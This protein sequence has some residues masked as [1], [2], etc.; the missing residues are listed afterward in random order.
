MRIVRYKLRG[1][2]N[3]LW[4]WV[5]EG[6]VGSLDGD[7]FGAFR[8]KKTYVSLDRVQL[9]P[10]VQ[11]GKIIAVGRNYA[12]HADE[13]GA[14]VPEIPLIFLKP[15]SSVIADGDTI[16]LP[17]QSE[18]VEHEAELAV[19]IGQGGRW[20]KRADAHKHVL[21]Y[22][23][24]VDVTARDLQ[25]SDTVWTRGKGFDTFCP[26]GPWIETDLDPS[27]L[28]IKCSVNGQLR[29]FGSTRDMVFSVPTVVAFISSV[30]TLNP[31]DLILTGTPAGV[32]PLT[33]GDQIE[34]EIEGIGTLSNN[35]KSDQRSAS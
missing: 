7:P 3:I 18:R 9:F 15:P 30:M 28:V 24:A 6:K 12:A 20:I 26:L 34:V 29:Q 1:G 13:F 35:V 10:P 8:R 32:G 21:G 17:P 19:V 2:K 11:P 22:S 5:S 16:L 23:I 31:G 27:D 33:G 4:G 14:S 25:R